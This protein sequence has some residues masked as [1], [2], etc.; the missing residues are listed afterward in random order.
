[1]GKVF[2]KKCIHL[3][4]DKRGNYRCI[5]PDNISIFKPVKENW[6]EEEKISIKHPM[7]INRNNDC[8]CFEDK[9]CLE[10]IKNFKSEKKNPC[11]EEDNTNKVYW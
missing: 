4:N 7:E 5:H 8:D 1:M 10:E 9:I 2:C 11:G 3:E 6:F